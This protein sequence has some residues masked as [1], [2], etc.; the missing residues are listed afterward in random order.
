VVIYSAFADD[1]IA[2]RAAIAGA[3]AVVPKASAPRALLSVL[4]NVGTGR[5]RLSLDPQAL[6]EA[7]RRLEPD[8]LSI[9]GMLA[10]GVAEDEIAATLG[11]DPEWLT[12]RRW[13]MLAR[14]GDG[15]RRRIAA[16]A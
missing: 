14:L 7:G 8:D 2:V 5:V 10:H 4:R 15:D 12:A 11:L 1:G 16:R 13:G 6:R 3:D 9:L